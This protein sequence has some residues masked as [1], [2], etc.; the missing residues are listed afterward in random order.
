MRPTEVE[1]GS[2]WATITGTSSVVSIETD[3]MG[4]LS[5]VEHDPELPQTGYG[6][7]SDLT[8]LLEEQY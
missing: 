8:R 3:L 7:Y 6:V 1:A 2:L 5:V 4:K